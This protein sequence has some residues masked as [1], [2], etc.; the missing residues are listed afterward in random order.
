MEIKINSLC[1]HEIGGADENT[2]YLNNF[3]EFLLD[4][5][6]STAYSLTNKGALSEELYYMVPFFESFY[7]SN[8][9]SCSANNDV[10]EI[11]NIGYNVYSLWLDENNNVKIKTVDILGTSGA[12]YPK[13]AK[14]TAIVKLDNVGTTF[15][16]KFKNN[17]AIVIGEN[18]LKNFA[19]FIEKHK[20]SITFATN[21]SV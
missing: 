16:D 5:A 13:Y 14:Y 18:D 21:A 12:N 4:R 10:C 11:I 20:D 8:P 7:D 9:Y 1:A 6:K 2:T 15:K 19:S 3:G 17:G